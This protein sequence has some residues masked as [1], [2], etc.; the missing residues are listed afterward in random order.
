MIG[1]IGMFGGLV[2]LIILTMRGMNL[3]I[4]AP[5]T[6]LFVAVLNGLPLLPQLA[7][8]GSVNF[9]SNYMTGFTGFIAS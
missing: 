4:A 9:L 2:L 8:D 5:L 6:A 1:M 3:L 7:A